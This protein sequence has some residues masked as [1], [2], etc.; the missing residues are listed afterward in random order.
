MRGPSPAVATAA[1]EPALACNVCARC[2]RCTAEIAAVLRDI[3]FWKGQAKTAI[4]RRDELDATIL[5][6]DG[7]VGYWRKASKELSA[8]L[9]ITRNELNALRTP[10]SYR[11]PSAKLLEERAEALVE[12]MTAAAEREEEVERRIA[13]ARD[14]LY[15]LQKAIGVDTPLGQE[16]HKAWETL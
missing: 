16:I 9:N 4:K 10:F 5:S 14:V 3:V 8:L 12:R 15:G 13:R 7:G 6:I 1:L 2:P 11:R